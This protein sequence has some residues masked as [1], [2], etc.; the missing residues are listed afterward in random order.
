MKWHAK[1]LKEVPALRIADRQLGPLVAGQE[2]EL[3]Q[4]ELVELERRGAVEAIPKF[5]LVEM[6]KLLLA[7]ERAEGLA[8]LPP[9]FYSMLAERISSLLSLNKLDEVEE[10]R[11]AARA[12]VELRMHKL[13][14]LA[15]SPESAENTLPEEMFLINRLVSSLQEWEKWLGGILKEAGEEVGENEFKKSTSPK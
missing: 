1:V 12:I 9:T 5:S 10:L 11:A 6:R 14:L 4:W 8:K 2:V 3:E 15:L 7:E 13:L